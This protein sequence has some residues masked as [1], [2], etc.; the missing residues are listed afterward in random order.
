L[1]FE[2]FKSMKTF[3]FSFLIIVSVFIPGYE[4]FDDIGSAIKSGSSEGVAKYFSSMVDLT[5]LDKEGNYSKQQATQILK[6]FFSKNPVKDFRII[7]RGEAKDGS[8]YAIGTLTSSSGVF[9]VY[10]LLTKN[11]EKMLMQQLRFEKE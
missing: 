8:K 4:V 3:F 10:F 6:D 5:I 2:S 9:R 11:G 1:I 7:H